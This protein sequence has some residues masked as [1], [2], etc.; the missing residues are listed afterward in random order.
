MNRN[1][2]L[3]IIR[4]EGDISRTQLVDHSG[5]SAGAVSQI[6]NDLLAYGWILEGGE[7]DYT[8][9]RRQ[10]VLR[11]NPSVGLALGIKLME[12][13][14]VC[15]L[16]DIVGN[17]LHYTEQA[18]PERKTPQGVTDALVTLVKHISASKHMHTAPLLGVGIGVAGVVHNQQ[19]VHYSPYFDWH[20]VPLAQLMSEQL[21]VPVYVENDVN[22]LT[23]TEHLF[24]A[25]KHQEN[26]VVVTV[27]R[28]VGMGIFLNN[29]PYIGA[30][31]GAGEIGHVPLLPDGSALETLAADPAVLRRYPFAKSLPE[32]VAA[33]ER[34]DMLAQQALAE[35]GR[36]LGMGLAMVVNILSP[37]L[38]IVSG[39]G[40]LAGEYRLEA[41]YD[42]LKRFA[43]NG[44]LDAVKIVIEP[45]DDRAWARGAA[46]LV[47]SRVFASPLLA[48]QERIG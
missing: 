30:T 16:T 1:L 6:I 37:S 22:T 35:S 44:L 25:G 11:L 33:A 34:G 8:G 20:N 15:A 7:G 4:R 23:L 41:M 45:T 27:G 24:G 31:G 29:Q 19:V 17:V 3:N 38:I 32:V 43:F 40:V 39:E 46:A 26:F 10:T 2:L 18:V 47:I 14:I 13:R 12:D 5:L 42:A 36:Y 28:G 9:G 21:D 48:G